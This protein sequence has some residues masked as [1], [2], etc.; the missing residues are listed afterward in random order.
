MV[1]I[2]NTLTFKAL[3]SASSLIWLSAHCASPALA[4]NNETDYPPP[5]KATSPAKA[6]AEVQAEYQ[7]AARDGTLQ[8]NDL[9]YPP[10]PKLPANSM[11]RSEVGA[12]Y[13]LALRNEM[14]PTN[15]EFA[16]SFLAKDTPSNLSREAVRA[17]TIEWLRASRGDVQMGSR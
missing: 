9:D 5:I 6:R 8:R 17:E 12:E 7:Q 3:V 14:R 10:T 2:M 15:N 1:L 4:L 16:P 13:T 11:T